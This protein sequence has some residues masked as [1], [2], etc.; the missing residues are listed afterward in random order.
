VVFQFRIA[1][2]LIHVKGMIL[3]QVRHHPNRILNQVCCLRNCF[4]FLI[5]F[6]LQ[7][8]RKKKKI[9][10]IRYIWATEEKQGHLN[11]SLNEKSILKKKTL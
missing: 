10:R 9:T 4:L 6:Y 1:L 5:F 11:V 3:I 2:I 8:E 7:D